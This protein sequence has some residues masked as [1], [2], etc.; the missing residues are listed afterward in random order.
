MPLKK[1]L[2]KC[3]LSLN[4][5]RKVIVV[6]FIFIKSTTAALIQLNNLVFGKFVASSLIDLLVFVGPLLED[7]RHTNSLYKFGHFRLWT[8]SWFSS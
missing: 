2:T 7:K 3:L 6:R 1:L 5:H 4:L 8:C